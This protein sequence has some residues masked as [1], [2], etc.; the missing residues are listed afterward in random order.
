MGRCPA[1][2]QEA[3]VEGAFSSRCITK[4]DYA[5]TVV[6]P[7]SGRHYLVKRRVGVWTMVALLTVT[8]CTCLIVAVC[9][10]AGHFAAHQKRVALCLASK[11][12]P[13]RDVRPLPHRRER[14]CPFFSC[15]DER[16][17]GARRGGAEFLIRT[18]RT[19]RLS[20]PSKHTRN[21]ASKLA[22]ASSHCLTS[23]ADF[24]GDERAVLSSLSNRQ[25]GSK[26]PFRC[27][28]GAP[29]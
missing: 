7:T 13:G 24:C 4:K 8:R 26:G 25:T 28:A 14:L 11:T 10:S 9:D 27:R 23:H 2:P 21:T 19:L 1:V 29:R 18:L 6:G 5:H 20:W 22:G 3:V 16:S 15:Y 17:G 12:P